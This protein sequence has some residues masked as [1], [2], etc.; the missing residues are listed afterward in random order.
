MTRKQF[1]VVATRIKEE[2]DNVK[3]LVKELS[4]R[5][6][7]GSKKNIRLALPHGDTFLLRAVGSIFAR[8]LCSCREYF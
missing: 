6:L 3:S 4:D 7:S 1:A 8:F 5:G 2:L